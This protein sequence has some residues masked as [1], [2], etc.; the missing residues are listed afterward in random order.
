LNCLYYR[1]LFG[2]ARVDKRDWKWAPGI[3]INI[4]VIKAIYRWIKE[5]RW[6]RR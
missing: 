2:E 4:E 5:K 1:N 3:R 6:R